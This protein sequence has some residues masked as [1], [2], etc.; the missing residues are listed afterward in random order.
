VSSG[1][2]ERFELLLHYVGTAF[3]GWQVQPGLRTV[4]GELEAVLARV[5]GGSRTVRGAGRTDAG[6]HATG[7][8]ATVDL[9]GRWTEARL[10]SA[11]NAL[12]PRDVWVAQVR[13]VPDTFHARYDAVA[14]SYEY[15]L[16]L[17]P[18]AFSPFHRPY[19]WALEAPVD[20]R[21]LEAGAALLGGE[22]SFLAFARSGQP[23][24]GD[25]CTVHE[26]GWREWDDLGLRFEVSANRYLHHM[27]RY[28]VGTMVD[29]ARA[30]RPLD[31]LVGLLERPGEG[32]VTSPPAP[33]AGLYLARVD[34]PS[35]AYEWTSVPEPRSRSTPEP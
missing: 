32:L 34:Y 33:P 28:L 27:V 21:S 24:R 11:L 31:D 25:R 22:H 23:Q 5:S 1:E 12:L 20:R 6:V 3:H 17:V 9:P 2:I 14:R 18:D 8:V 13:K 29:I 10:G 16:G 4:Q 15:R 26:A 19:C 35:R 30:R 7:Q